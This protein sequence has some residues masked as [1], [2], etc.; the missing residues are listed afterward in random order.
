MSHVIF[1]GHNDLLFRLMERCGKDTPEQVIAQC[2]QGTPAGHL[3]VPRMQSGRFGGGLCAVFIPPTGTSMNFEKMNGG[4]YQLPLPPPIDYKDALPVAIEQ[5]AL[6][7]RLVEASHGALVACTTRAHI[8]RCMRDQKIAVVLHME[9]AEAIDEALLAL[10]VW[11]AAG[12]RSLGPVWS[13]NT[14]FADGVPFAFPATPNIGNGLTPAGERLIKACNEKKILI[15]LSHLN[16]AG[17]WDVARLSDAPLV[18][19]HSNAWQLCNSAR[20]LTDEQLHAI[21]DSGGVVGMNYATCFVRQDGRMT[22]DTNLDSLLNHIDHTLNI[23]GENGVALGSDF[24][25]A[26]VP[27][28]IGDVSGLDALRD[29]FRQRGY[30]EDL[31]RQLCFGNWLNVLERT[32]G[33]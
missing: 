30:S 9:G 28:A 7:L 20:N 26:V 18:A 1:D 29:A 3:D 14:L 16:E 19:T 12:L 5:I 23:V 17:F 25:G 15:D 13:R 8:D 33:E 31:Q 11:Y 24:D 6:F 21:K 2:I 4:G 10:E 32:W 22:S 27:K